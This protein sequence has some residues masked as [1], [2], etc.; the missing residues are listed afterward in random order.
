MPEDEELAW[1]GTEHQQIFASVH[2]LVI[3]E[4]G[5]PDIDVVF[6]HYP[7]PHL[8]SIDSG[9]SASWNAAGYVANLQRMDGV[10][11]DIRAALERVDLWNSATVLASSDHSLRADVW[12]DY[13]RR[14]PDIRRLVGDAPSTRVPFILKL[15]NERTG[16]EYGRRFSATL[17]RELVVELVAG[18]IVDVDGLT[19][20]LDRRRVTSPQD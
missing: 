17:S 10:L 2:N 15:A 12:A 7:V 6:A 19:A 14:A 4:A 8:P 16:R 18:R 20:W 3:R 9:P 13:P 11:A 1:I 5:R